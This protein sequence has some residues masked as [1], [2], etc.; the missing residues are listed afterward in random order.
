MKRGN[1]TTTHERTSSAVL[2]ERLTGQGLDE[3]QYES[4]DRAIHILLTDAVVGPQTDLV[5]TYRDGAY[6]VWAQ[7]GMIRFVR[8]YAGAPAASLNQK[9]TW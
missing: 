1:M 9:R 2:P 8:E 4:G 6:E 7:R 5:I 3:H